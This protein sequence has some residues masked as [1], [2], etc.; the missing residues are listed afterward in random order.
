MNFRKYMMVLVVIAIV[1]TAFTG[2]AATGAKNSEAVAS[3]KQ[4]TLSES[5]LSEQVIKT[6]GMQS[7]LDLVDSGILAELEPMTEQMTAAVDERIAEIKTQYADSFEQTLQIN[8]FETEADFKKFLIL[9]AQRQAYITKYVA[10]TV[11]TEDEMKAYYEQYAPEIQASHILIQAVDDSESALKVA[12]EQA[13]DITKRINAGEDFA[14]LAKE[15]SKDPGSGALGGDLGSFGKGQMVPEFEAAVY[16]L[17]VGDMTKEPVKTQFGYHIIKK[18]GEG[19]KLSYDEMKPE[20]TKTLA[21]EKL[22]ADQNL[23]SKAL[24]KL[25]ADNG[26]QIK[27]PTLAQQYK[28]YTEQLSQ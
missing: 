12:E 18:T 2:C 16:A 5:I 4:G 9:D 11:V 1:A 13:I 17:K 28:L 3:Y 7:L 15:F 19:Q 23:A 25:R 6:A 24:I 20:I 10:T 14:T 26:L 21:D 22:M 27:N 8:G